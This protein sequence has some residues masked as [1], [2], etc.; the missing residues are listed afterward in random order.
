MVYRFC[1]ASDI[2]GDDAYY[3]AENCL[4]Y[5]AYLLERDPDA[6]AL[7]V[8]GVLPAMMDAWYGLRGLY[9]PAR[10]QLLRDVSERAPELAERLRQALRA[11]DA[12]ERVHL[13]RRLLAALRGDAEIV[14]VAAPS[15]P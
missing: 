1:V 10:D 4:A 7:L 15:R 8:N 9:P 13:A 3:D 11:A 14:A 2:H 6:A 12:P 5:A